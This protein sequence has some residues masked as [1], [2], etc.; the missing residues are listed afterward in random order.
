MEP[1][2]L[3]MPTSPSLPMSSVH[4]PRPPW[5]VQ[6]GGQPPQPPNGRP[7][8]PL[9]AMIGAGLAVIVIVALL[10]TLLLTTRGGTT[11]V[12]LR[13]AEQTATSVQATSTAEGTPPTS[14]TGTGGTSGP[15]ATATPRPPGPVVAIAMASGSGSSELSA[16]CPTG[17]LALSGGWSIGSGARLFMTHRSGNGW[18]V[19]PTPPNGGSA[20][21]F[22]LCLQHAAGVSI[23]QR[24]T[25]FAIAAN[26]SGTG[27][28]ACDAGEILAGGGFSGD[29]TNVDIS[30][31]SPSADHTGF[32]LTAANHDTSSQQAMFVYAECLSAP[33]AHLTVP[34]PTQVGVSAHGSAPVQVSCPKGTLLSGGGIDLLNGVAV[35]THFAPNSATTWLAEVQNQTFVGMTVKLYALCLSFT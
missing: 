16:S 33:K 3:D 27:V 30:H 26:S 35:A 17:E 1:D 18:M 2:P 9:L 24:E 14:P 8:W 34:A 25:I 19:E 28:A 7:R 29:G 10:F 21:A 20:N 12:L 13:G 6:A 15:H 5:P 22:V 11:T 23:T 31:F 4:S 32:I